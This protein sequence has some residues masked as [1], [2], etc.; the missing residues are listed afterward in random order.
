METLN[1]IS[2]KLHDGEPDIGV[3]RTEGYLYVDKTEYIVNLFN[4]GRRVFM[5]RPPSCL[6]RLTIFTS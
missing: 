6:T 5:A 3:L 2:N 1:Q 4:K